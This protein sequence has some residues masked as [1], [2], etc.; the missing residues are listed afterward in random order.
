MRKKTA[1]ITSL[2]T[3]DIKD[4]EVNI[5]N[6]S[7]VRYDGE[8]TGRVVKYLRNDIRYETV[9]IRKIELNCWS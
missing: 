6:Y 9:L 3:I 5:S 8:N 7:I 4:Y 1:V 2:L